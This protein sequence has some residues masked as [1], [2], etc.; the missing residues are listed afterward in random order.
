M[1][2][3]LVHEIE[4][5]YQKFLDLTPEE[6]QEILLQF[7]SAQSHLFDF[8]AKE[9]DE[10]LNT[11]ESDLFYYYLL[12]IWFLM[13]EKDEI[14]TVSKKLIGNIIK[15]YHS[16]FNE[17]MEKFNS[18]LGKQTGLLCYEFNQSEFLK[19]IYEKFMEDLDLSFETRG[20]NISKIMFYLR[21][22]TAC[23]DY[24]PVDETLLKISD[25]ILGPN[26]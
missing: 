20:R 13:K 26:F 16:I 23:F 14:Y 6:Y 4:P 1:N 7:I 8:L 22:T 25:K 11:E 10:D 18:D 21:I 19:F 9:L 17:I 24:K 2:P 15:K 3:I 12:L 5:L